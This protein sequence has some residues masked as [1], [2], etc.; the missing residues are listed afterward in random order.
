MRLGFHIPFHFVPDTIH[1]LGTDLLATGIYDWIEVKYAYDIVGFDPEPYDAAI[2][3]VISEHGPGV[4]LHV[5]T[6]YD[7][8]MWSEAVRET[9]LSQIEASIRY[10]AELGATV[11]PIHPGTILHMDIPA[12]NS[13]PDTRVVLEAS[14]RKK[15]RARRLTIDA[16]SRLGDYA[17]HHNIIL[18]LE[19]VLLPQEIVYTSEQLADIIDAVNHPHVR[20]LF[21]SGHANRVGKDSASF[22]RTLG[23]RLSHVH[24]NDNDGSC[25]LHQQ[26]GAGSVDFSS[27]FAALD[28]SDFTGA[29][30]VETAYGEADDLAESAK[31]IA[32]YRN[33]GE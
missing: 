24:I 28:G 29:V 13:R 6:H 18:T 3:S 26:L 16:L 20:A 14:R 31:R 19:N 21:D 4:S 22:V 7:V 25:D 12:T 15:Q 5:P 32:G 2:R 27:L 8:G 23:N 9:I 1:S 11:M 17:G 30:V 10:A 33:S